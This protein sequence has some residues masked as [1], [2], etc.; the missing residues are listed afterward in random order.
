MVLNGTPRDANENSRRSIQLLR[1]VAL[2]SPSVTRTAVCD[3]LTWAPAVKP[4]CLAIFLKVRMA[5]P[6]AHRQKRR[7]PVWLA[8]INNV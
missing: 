4:G 6:I 2:V 1:K 5:S 7:I 8:G 3:T